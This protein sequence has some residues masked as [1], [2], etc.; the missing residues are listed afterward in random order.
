MSNCS[1]HN[2]TH[3]PSKKKYDSLSAAH[4][5]L[6][7]HT[8]KHPDIP[9]C[10][11]VCIF[12]TQLLRYALAIARRHVIFEMHA[13]APRHIRTQNIYQTFH[14][15]PIDKEMNTKASITRIHTHAHTSRRPVPRKAKTQPLAMC[16]NVSSRKTCGRRPASHLHICA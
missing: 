1:A 16:S 15:C 10:T 7:T 12:K 14:G 5:H 2:N 6:R 11:C 8:E 9:A 13:W 3:V 4:M